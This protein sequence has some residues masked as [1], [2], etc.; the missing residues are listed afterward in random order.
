[1][2]E[3]LGYSL[4]KHNINARRI[5]MVTKETNTVGIIDRLEFAG[6]TTKLVHVIPQPGKPSPT[7]RFRQMFT[8][9]HICFVSN[10]KSSTPDPS[11]FW[12][13]YE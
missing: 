2:A 8:K 6:W 3:V 12:W 1:M 5:M 10:V 4:M 13:H 9:L 7:M 11:F